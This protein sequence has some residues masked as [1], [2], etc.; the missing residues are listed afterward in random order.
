MKNFP[1][2]LCAYFLMAIPLFVACEKENVLR[3]I[4]P[5]LQVTPAFLK[6][7]DKYLEFSS[8]QAFSDSVKL[9]STL[10]RYQLDRWEDEKGFVSLR[11][12]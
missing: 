2:K 4:D 7:E 9:L 3:D 12:M 1:I 6:N 10:T 5:S 11:R 8:R